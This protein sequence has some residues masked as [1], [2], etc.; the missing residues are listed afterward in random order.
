[1]TI[2][3]QQKVV[4]A[5]FYTIVEDFSPAATVKICFEM[6]LLLAFGQ[7]PIYVF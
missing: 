2:D 5:I 4:I 7:V 1:M 6:S 3:S